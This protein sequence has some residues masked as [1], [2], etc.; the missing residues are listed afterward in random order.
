VGRAVI[1]PGLE[2]RDLPAVGAAV[3]AAAAGVVG[4][5]GITQLGCPPGCAALRAHPQQQQLPRSWLD[6]QAQALQAR[7]EEVRQRLSELEAEKQ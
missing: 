1:A 6:N 4:G 5:T 2:D 7:L 3:L